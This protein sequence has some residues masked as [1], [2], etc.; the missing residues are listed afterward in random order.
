MFQNEIEWDETI[1]TLLDDNGV[2]E[3][4]QLFIGDNDVLIRQWNEEFERYDIIAMD[5]KMLF[6]LQQA[7]HQGEGL[8]RIEM[9]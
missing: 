7:L 4:V 3:D 9:N 2:L 8:F 1:T 5:H 6:E